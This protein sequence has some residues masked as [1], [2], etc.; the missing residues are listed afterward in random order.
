MGIYFLTVGAGSFDGTEHALILIYRQLA[1]IDSHHLYP[2][3]EVC[4]PIIPLATI[5]NGF[6]TRTEALLSD[7]TINLTR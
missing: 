2:P 1:A 6:R 3:V 7:M 5:Q 4:R